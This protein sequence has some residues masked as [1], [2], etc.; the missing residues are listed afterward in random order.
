MVGSTDA[1]AVISD[2]DTVKGA[3]MTEAVEGLLLWEPSEEL[4]KDAN[5]SR[6]MRWL[7]DEKGLS[8]DDY[9][10]LWEWSV[11]ELEEFWA[12]IWEFFEVKASKPYDK[13][14]NSREM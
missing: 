11:T 1:G 7:E 8:F 13:V 14:L 4:K 5:I 12:S 3:R 9:G 6:Y 10:E 2:A